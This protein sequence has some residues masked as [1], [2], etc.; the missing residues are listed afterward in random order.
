VTKEGSSIVV[1]EEKDSS[2][3]ASNSSKMR[4]RNV[5]MGNRQTPDIQVD[6]GS[7]ESDAQ[8]SLPSNRSILQSSVIEEVDESSKR[9]D[10][11][12]TRIQEKVVSVSR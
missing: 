12:P 10:S 11:K 1:F 9:L 7:L 4:V 8:L 6:L 5:R 2:S 3:K